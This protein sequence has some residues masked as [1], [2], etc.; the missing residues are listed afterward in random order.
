[1]K[2]FKISDEAKKTKI[3]TK[4]LLDLSKVN[5][6]RENYRETKQQ[7]NKILQGSNT[8]LKEARKMHFKGAT[9]MLIKQL[10]EYIEVVKMERIGLEKILL[11]LTK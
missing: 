10:D 4:Q 8:I 7:I 6:S 1:M 2:L 5:L 11:D 3:I 9:P